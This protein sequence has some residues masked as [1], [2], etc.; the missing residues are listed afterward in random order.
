MRRLTLVL[1]VT[2]PA[3]LVTGAEPPNPVAAPRRTVELPSY[4][5]RLS[6]PVLVARSKGFLWFPT[7]HRLPDGKL[8]AVM[9]DYADTHVKRATAKLSWSG[10]SGA[11]W[12]A[13]KPAIYGDVAVPQSNG[14]LLLLPYYLYP[15]KV[16]MGAPAQVVPKGKEAVID[17]GE[18]TFTNWPKPDKNFEP[19]LGLAGFVTN[20]QIVPR[21]D[22]GWLM[23]LYGWFKDDKRYSLVVAESD[24]GKNWKVRS[25]IAGPE[26]KLAGAEGPCEAALARLKDGRLLCVYR[27]ASNV[28]YGHSF[29]SDDGK[30]WTEP[31]SLPKD[32][33]S[34]QPSLVV[35]KDGAIALS[36]GRPGVFLYLNAA[37]DARAW[38]KVDLMA[39][40]NATVPTKEMILGVGNTS[41]YTEVVALDD[42]NL[43]V[44][45]DRI[46]HSWNAIPSDSTET[47]SVWVVRVTLDQKK[48]KPMTGGRTGLTPELKQ[49]CLDI[50]R[51]GLRNHA[52]EFYPAVHAAEGLTLAGHGDEVKEVFG[53][54]LKTE[55]DG[56]KKCGLARELARAG[57]RDKAAIIVALVSDTAANVNAAESLYKIGEIGDGKALRQAYAQTDN[58]A[59]RMMAAAALAKKGDAEALAFLRKML[60]DPKNSMYASWAL[61]RIGDQSDIA[62]IQKLIALEKRPFEKAFG[63]QALATLGDAG[64][65]AA[66]ARHFKAENVDTRALAAEAAGH[67]GAVELVPQLIGLLDDPVPDVRYRAA[68]AL[69]MLERQE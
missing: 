6:Q 66:L 60:A 15:H 13:T 18:A 49:R 11:T 21:S 27:L 36:G 51:K 20:G 40:H 22:N 56:K 35:L 47:N 55:T 8:L 34:V 46:P 53:P 5:V 48:E 61:G 52:D 67:A 50:L 17:A 62:A 9:S 2:I 69:L 1:F 7:I 44:I 43:L 42:K 41:A 30:T 33:F 45:Y 38:E 58:A 24:E 16:G 3:T 29:S 64:G 25:V 63:E 32:V 68:Q 28:P 19:K 26:C 54:L 37:G 12:T 31:A 10:D 65:K 57:E 4:K 14:D 23:T 59:L 39:H